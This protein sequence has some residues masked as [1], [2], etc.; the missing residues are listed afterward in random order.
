MTDRRRPG[1]LHKFGTRSGNGRQFNALH[2]LV[3]DQFRQELRVLG[4]ACCA[5]SAVSVGGILPHRLVIGLGQL[6]Q[7][8]EMYS[9]N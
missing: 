7:F 8:G 5:R 3:G 9:N 4:G 6:S 2:G 1:G